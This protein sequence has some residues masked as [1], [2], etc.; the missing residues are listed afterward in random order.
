MMSNNNNTAMMEEGS[1]SK[2]IK[3]DLVDLN[4]RL[5]LIKTLAASKLLL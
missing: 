4:E 2:E 1:N 3:S 5:F